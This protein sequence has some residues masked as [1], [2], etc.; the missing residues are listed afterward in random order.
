MFQQE[1]NTYSRKLSLT[2]SVKICKCSGTIYS[3]KAPTLFAV[4]ELHIL[5][6]LCKSGTIINKEDNFFVAVGTMTKR[7]ERGG[8]FHCAR[9][10][11]GEGA[12]SSYSKR[13]GYSTLL[14]LDDENDVGLQHLD[15]SGNLLSGLPL[16]L[17]VLSNLTH[18]RNGGRREAGL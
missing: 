5:L 12:N 10:G 7:W 13:V 14:L 11:V 9:S 16:A 18:L 17:G 1:T 8:L 3:K 15:L 4:H 6:W 2:L